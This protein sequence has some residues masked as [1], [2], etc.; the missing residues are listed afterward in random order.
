[1]DLATPLRSLV[2]T[3]D[4]EALTVL[5]GTTAPLTGNRLAGLAP[6]GSRAGLMRV[7][8]R[9]VAHGLVLAEPA[10]AA[11]LYRLNREHL[12][13][14]P[15]LATVQARRRLLDRL[16]AELESWASPCLHA[17]V[18]G[19]VARGDATTSSDI[20]LLLVRPVGLEADETGWQ[21]Q[22]RRL[23]ASV[24]AW[25]GN[26]LAILE[27]TPSDLARSRDAGEPL[28]QAL[29]EDAIVL[30]GRTVPALLADA[31]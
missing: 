22:V 14:E 18:F 17:S 3:L 26:A 12:L 7:L 29:Q 19:S 5:A 27:L 30:V 21:R 1:M 11:T 16:R 4:A 8:E 2:P 20:D 23:E 25:T 31:S 6:R 15:L 13:C 9:L 10:G 24:E 28:L